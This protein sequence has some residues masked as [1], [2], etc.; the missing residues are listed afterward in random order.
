MDSNK[1]W[2]ESDR[3]QNFS[4][5][6]TYNISTKIKPGEL[7]FNCDMILLINHTANLKKHDDKQKLVIKNNMQEN[8]K[9]I[10]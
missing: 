6:S 2:R 4:I 9:Y 8:T 7:M 5:L 1:P 10:E 3:Q